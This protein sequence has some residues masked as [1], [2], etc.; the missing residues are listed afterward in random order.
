MLTYEIGIG[1]IELIILIFALNG[2]NR[3]LNNSQ[4]ISLGWLVISVNF[5]I[6]IIYICF[7]LIENF[8]YI[9]KIIQKI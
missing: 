3:F 6:I 2:E 8:L 5:I 4:F 9:K 7:D 1:F